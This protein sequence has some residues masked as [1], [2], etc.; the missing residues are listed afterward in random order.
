MRNDPP[1]TNA[2]FERRSHVRP[3]ANG[4]GHLIRQAA[5]MHHLGVDDD[6]GR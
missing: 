2:V 6:P 3:R 1:S 4:R 5:R